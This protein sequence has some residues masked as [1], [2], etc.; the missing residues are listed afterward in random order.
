M[1][2]KSA[3]EIMS[4][5][6]LAVSANESL[7][8]VFKLF[9]DHSFRHVPVVNSEK[10][11]VGIVSDRD[12]M[13]ICIDDQGSSMTF[14]D[15]APYLSDHTVGEVMTVD[16]E[17]IEEECALNEACEILLDN[18]FDALPVVRGRRLVGILTTSDVLREMTK[19]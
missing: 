5:K 16:P 17:V 19:P 14:T 15:K 1:S 2:E 4:H 7:S 9:R 18:K 13:R 10:E 3:S 6:V 12:L 11:V 8:E